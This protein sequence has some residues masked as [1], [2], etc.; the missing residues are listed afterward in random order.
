MAENHHRIASERDLSRWMDENA[1]V[2]WL[3]IPDPW[4]L[5]THLL[6]TLDL[7]LNVGCQVN[8]TTS[9]LVLP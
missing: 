1:Y 4:L 9:V 7:P 6:E 2:S 5:E 3:P 8:G